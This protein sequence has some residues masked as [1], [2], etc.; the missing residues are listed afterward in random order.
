VKLD[1]QG[2]KDL[3]I[4]N[5]I[6]ETAKAI[7]GTLFGSG[8]NATGYPRPSNDYLW[9]IGFVRYFDWNNDCRN[10]AYS[11]EELKDKLDLNTPVKTS[12]MMF[13]A[14]LFSVLI[15]GVFWPIKYLKRR[16]LEE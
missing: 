14:T 5:N 2:E 8:I 10:G 13:A 3:F 1:V 12:W 6:Y 16:M 7:P 15:T 4:Q 9:M 11:M